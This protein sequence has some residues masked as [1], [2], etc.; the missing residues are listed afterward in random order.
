MF[1]LFIVME[2]GWS[3]RKSDWNSL[4]SMLSQTNQQLKWRQC[5][6]EKIH[7]NIIP[8]EPGVYMLCLSPP[9]CE[10]YF[11]TELPIFNALYRGSTGNLRKRFNNYTRKQNISSDRAK[12]FLGNFAAIITFVYTTCSES[13]MKQIEGRL[14]DAFGPSANGRR[15]SIGRYHAV[16]EAGHLL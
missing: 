10:Q 13:K 9:Y 14:I 12:Y 4:S 2:Y 5:P 3:L 11:D 6:L 16:A 1:G 15:E 7:R 8:E